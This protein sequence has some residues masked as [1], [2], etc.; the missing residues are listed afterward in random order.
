VYPA[1]IGITL[2]VFAHVLPRS[3]MRYAMTMLVGVVGLVML[4]GCG[5]DESEGG[6][7]AGDAER[8]FAVGSS[9]SKNESSIE[10]VWE[11]KSPRVQSGLESMIRLELRADR[12]VAAVRCTPNGGGDATL[13]GKSARAAVSAT[14][15]DVPEEVRV[16]KPI[17]SSYCGVVFRAGTLPT[18]DARLSPS[19][20]KS[21][22]ELSK[23]V[24]V[25]REDIAAVEYVKVSD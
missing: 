15:I 1:I 25:V 8:I 4:A 7:P 20:R 19:E 11:A 10:G 17:G 6:A 24:L 13:L 16:S 12:M 9:E 18:C 2:L 3:V 22:F 14:T 21:C 23:G 5:E